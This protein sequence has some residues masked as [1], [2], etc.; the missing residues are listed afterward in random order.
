[1][2]KQSLTSN[3]FYLAF[4]LFAFTPKGLQLK[5][6]LT[7]GTS[8]IAEAQKDFGV[9]YDIAHFGVPT[10]IA[11]YPLNINSTIHDFAERPPY[12]ASASNVEFTSG[13]ANES[14]GA[15]KFK[16]ATDSF[17]QFP[18]TGG[19]LDAKYSIT[20]MCWVRPGGQDGPLFNYKRQGAWGVHIWIALNG[21]FFVRITK[22]GSHAFLPHLSTDQ[23]LERGRWY[24]VAATYDSNTGVNSIYV[25]G[26]L[27]KT[28]NIGT[29]YRISTN[30]PTIRMG[31]KIGD[32][33]LFN[34]AITQMG[35]YNVS[36]TGDQIRTLIKQALK[37]R[38]CSSSPCK[39]G[40]TCSEFGQ[41]LFH[42]ICPEGFTGPTCT[43]DINECLQDNSGCQ[44]QCVNTE[45]GYYCA[46]SDP[47]L[48]L[49]ADKSHCIAEGVA[50]EC[51]QNDMVI[52]LPKSLL[53]G[54]DRHHI[55]LMDRNCRAYENETHF[56]LQTQ[57]I[58]CKTQ[59]RHR[60]NFAIYS[61]M[62]TEIPLEEGQIVTRVRDIAIPFQCFYSE[63]GVVSSIGIKPV[64]KK[65]ITSAR[66]MGKFTLTLDL[67]RNSS[68]QST[69]SQDEFPVTLNL[70]Q[71]LYFESQ[72]Q[73]EDSRL[74]ILALECYATPSQD[75]TAQ[76]RYNL[77]ENGCSV[78]ETLSFHPRP[79]P[80]SERWSIEAFQYV[81]RD[82]PFVF[83]HCKI[84]V[85]N[86]TD[87]NSRC[88][89]G[90]QP[91]RKRRDAETFPETPDDVY[92]LAQGPFALSPEKRDSVSFDS[93]HSVH[94]KNK[95][96]QVPIEVALFM[97]IGVCIVGTI[98]LVYQKRRDAVRSYQPLYIAE[99]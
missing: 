52:N 78:D 85:C 11:F 31:V 59:L 84:K 88:A 10:P 42:C 67:Y 49:A 60:G 97:I 38:P 75:R 63:L 54:V 24:H 50:L 55:I 69:Y 76:P 4:L 44:D 12:S 26:V 16:G 41:N 93:D 57:L 96:V 27:N 40:G 90:C 74:S 37:S 3:F 72:V 61:N 89:Q 32:S 81:N 77:I 15:Y 68:Y 99:N 70:R 92:P 46:C 23:P 18:N 6:T 7:K 94:L 1:M 82:N 47:E 34:G 80:Q 66:G 79:D 20:L 14:N 25:D 71:Q 87:P 36:L 28:Q 19:I 43:H 48:S 33:R 91:S 8:K 56:I 30:D 58:G 95:N 39:N 9:E 13:P 98:Y 51:E 73:T 17:I 65:V 64:S 22:F 5:D 83:I 2:K 86:A 62:V 45:G 53:R 29:G 35:I 21:R